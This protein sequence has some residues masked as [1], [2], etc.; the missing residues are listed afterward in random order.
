MVCELSLYLKNGDDAISDL[1]EKTEY[2][3]CESVIW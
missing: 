1:P 2:F 3:V